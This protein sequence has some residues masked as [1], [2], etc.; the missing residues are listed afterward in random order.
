MSA[1]TSTSSTVDRATDLEHLKV[2]RETGL[3]ISEKRATRVYYRVRPEVQERLAAVLLPVEQGVEV[4][5]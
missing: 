3:V 1:D 4:P 5:A 2:L